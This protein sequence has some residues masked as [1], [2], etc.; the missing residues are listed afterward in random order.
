MKAGKNMDSSDL[1]LVGFDN[2][3]KDI[4]VLVV[5]R[6]DSKNNIRMVNPIQGTDAIHIYEKL[7]GEDSKIGSAR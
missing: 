5:S 1:L 7:V 6:R 3:D 2:S 4:A